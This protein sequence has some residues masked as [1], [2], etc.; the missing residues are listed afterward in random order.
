M[1]LF[2][3]TDEVLLW[4][5]VPGGL[6]LGFGEGWTPDALLPLVVVGGMGVMVTPL[7]NS[8]LCLS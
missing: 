2:L 3:E 8:R 6:P 5:F 1:L 7:L 4:F